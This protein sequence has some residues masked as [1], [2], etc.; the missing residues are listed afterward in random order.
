MKEAVAVG[1]HRH[2]ESKKEYS[3][4]LDNS[5]LGCRRSDLT[6]EES[7]RLYSSYFEDS[8]SLTQLDL[9]FML[10]SKPPNVK[11]KAVPYFDARDLSEHDKISFV[12]K[13]SRYRYNIPSH[14]DIARSKPPP[15]FTWIQSLNPPPG[16]EQIN[17]DLYARK[18]NKF[19]VFN[20]AGVVSWQGTEPK[21]KLMILSKEAFPSNDTILECLGIDFA[22]SAVSK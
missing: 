5:T 11:E 7:M 6:T 10:G 14:S 9:T 20:S 13:A 15:L 3:E 18:D 17:E 16:F 22:A 4:L 2:E 19:M 12:E 8:S 1:W 21:T